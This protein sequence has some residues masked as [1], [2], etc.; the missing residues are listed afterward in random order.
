MF[1]IIQKEALKEQVGTQ[2]KSEGRVSKLNTSKKSDKV[3]SKDSKKAGADP[4]F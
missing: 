2:K 4:D 3:A 1:L